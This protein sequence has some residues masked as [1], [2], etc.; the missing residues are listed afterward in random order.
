MHELPEDERIALMG[1]TVML[2]RL[3]V[4]ILTDSS[5]P[6]KVERYRQKMA[7]TFPLLVLGEIKRE[8]PT[9]GSA[10]FKCDPPPFN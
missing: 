3:S 10:G 6:D 5:P 9:P 7:A 8:F 2:N 4:W 1:S